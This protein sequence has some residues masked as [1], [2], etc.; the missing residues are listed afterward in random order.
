MASERLSREAWIA[1]GFLSL[2]QDGPASLKINL[3]AH[4][5]GTTKGSFYWHF[6][7]LD[8]FKNGMLSLWKSKAA[9]EIIDRVECADTPWQ[10]LDILLS[11]AARSAPDEYG[12]SDIEPAMRAWSLSDSDVAEALLELD[13]LR[14]SFLSQILRDLKIESPVAAELV[15]AAY[16]GLSDL[17]SKGR[18]DIGT[19]LGTLQN[20]ILA[21]PWD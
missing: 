18:A 8:D 17:H 12:G 11:N 2:A 7:D 20:M 15:Y 4:R 6:R 14:I 13:T 1:T 9:T 16:I 5:L 10:Q 19:A 3:L 21:Y